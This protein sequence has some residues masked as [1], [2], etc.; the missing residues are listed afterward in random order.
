MGASEVQI[1]T[2]GNRKGFEVILKER[3]L[4]HPSNWDEKKRSRGTVN[5]ER[6]R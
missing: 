4:E 2:E 3:E 5:T 6:E 1:G